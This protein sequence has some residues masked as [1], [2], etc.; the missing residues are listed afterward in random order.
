MVPAAARKILTSDT[1]C[2]VNINLC[3]VQNLCVNE[4]VRRLGSIQRINDRCMEMQKNKH[5]ESGSH[6]S[7]ITVDFTEEHFYAA[8]IESSAMLVFLPTLRFVEKQNCEEGVKR[9]RGPAK[10]VCP[11][12]KA[13]AL[14]QMRDEVLGTI[15]DIEQL[16]K[17]G[18]ETHSCPYYATRLAI[19]TAQVTQ[20]SL[21]SVHP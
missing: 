10:S 4:E 19:P 18:R 16:L 20:C 14:Q 1:I 8:C 21:Y 2:P 15:H 3:T 6:T 5:G 12:N 9:K 13:S 7:S 11:F 17:L